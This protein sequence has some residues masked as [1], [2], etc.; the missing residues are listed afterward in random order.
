ME[1]LTYIFMTNEQKLKHILSHL[2]R[3]KKPKENH[4]I[5]ILKEY[6]EFIGQSLEYFR[7]ND[8][9]SHFETMTAYYRVVGKTNS[10][11]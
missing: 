11:F 9:T 10:R 6:E 3:K 5:D 4:I 8:P 7:K 1:R 2:K